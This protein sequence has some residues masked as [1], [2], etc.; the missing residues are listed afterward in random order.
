[1][2]AWKA[3]VK[4]EARNF[5]GDKVSIETLECSHVVTIP[6]NGKQDTVTRLCRKCPPG[7]FH[8]LTGNSWY[9]AKARAHGG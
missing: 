7:P 9:A 8:G 5:G 6:S 2:A 3:V 1:M 4:R